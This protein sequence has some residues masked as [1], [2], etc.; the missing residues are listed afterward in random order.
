MKYLNPPLRPRNGLV[1]WVLRVARISTLNQD[2]LSL[3]DQEDMHRRWV[4][5]YY[6]GSVEYQSVSTQGSGECLDRKELEVIRDLV[7]SGRFDVVIMEDLARY[8]RDFQALEFCGFCIDYGNRLIAITDQIDTAVPNWEDAAMFA[9]WRHKKYNHDT[10]RRIKQ[11]LA[12]RFEREGLI[13]SVLYGYVKPPGATTDDKVYKDPAAE[14]VYD[15]WFALLEDGATYAE[16]ADW[17]NAKNVPVGPCC[18]LEKWD[19][20]MV[21][22]IT[23]NPIVKGVRVRNRMYTVKHHQSG[24]RRSVKCDTPRFRA[25]PHLAFIETERYDRLIR[26]LNARNGHFRRKNVNGGDP[27]AGRPKRR[28]TWP[29]RHCLC[30][31]CGRYFHFG[32][33]G[34]RDHLFCKGAKAHRCWNGV[35]ISG[36]DAA[37]RIADRIV[38]EIEA[39]PNFDEVFLEQVRQA[40]ERRDADRS[41]RLEQFARK[42]AK[43]KR[44]E[45]NLV[46]SIKEVGLSPLLKE[47]LDRI[48]QERESLEIARDEAKRAAGTAVVIPP[49]DQIKAQARAAFTELACDDGEFSRRV[50]R[51]IRRIV[52]VPYRLCDDGAVVL[53]ARF[54]LNLAPLIPGGEGV[55]GLA[56]RLSREVEVDLFDP[57]QREAYRHRAMQAL[58]ERPGVTQKAVGAQLGI[59]ATAVQRA[60]R[61]HHM[62]TQRGLTEAYVCVTQAPM[63][64]K[65]MRR[66]LHGRYRFEPLGR[67]ED[68]PE[69]SDDPG[70]DFGR[71]VDADQTGQAAP[72]P[73]SLPTLDCHQSDAANAAA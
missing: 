24:H 34:R 9:A 4:E 28:T 35:S 26:L 18:D 52:L 31:V 11:R 12:N 10:S 72:A 15:R 64:S 23:H 22:R 49:M 1:L 70:A 47:E 8:M 13:A 16:V 37:R 66:H 43:L 44:Q 19:A 68:E 58:T 54:T 17:L 45:Q 14:A 57:P 53:R 59:T 48:L 2:R 3:R 5:E 6:D 73:P 69:V 33:H 42:S 50:M 39:L 25:C 63:D 27:R 21:S 71:E 20:A 40:V 7:A 51:L 61:L 65:R 32:A 67:F 38:S 36:P 29:G 30:G 46:N 41:S 60:V 55:E 56:P 62:I